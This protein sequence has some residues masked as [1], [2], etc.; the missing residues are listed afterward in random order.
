MS[1][2]E[3]AVLPSTAWPVH[4]VYVTTYAYNG[5]PG[6]VEITT[7]GEVYAYSLNSSDAQAFT[8][9]AGISYPVGS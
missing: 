4:D 2:E 7:N 8:S 5:A 9:L 1:S 6:A 3:A